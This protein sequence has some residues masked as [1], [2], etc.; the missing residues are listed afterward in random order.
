MIT[1]KKKQQLW[2]MPANSDEEDQ[3]YKLVMK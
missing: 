2:S 1:R 3:L